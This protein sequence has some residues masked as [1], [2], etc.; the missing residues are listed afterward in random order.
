MSANDS[1]DDLRQRVQLEVARRLEQIMETPDAL[2]RY[3]RDGDGELDDEE[4]AVMRAILEAEVVHDLDD[5]PTTANP[6]QPRAAVAAEWTIDDE[7]DDP[8]IEM[9]VLELIDA[10]Y[11]VLKEIGRGAQGKTYLSR[12][13]RDARYVI[14]KELPFEQ[15]GSWKEL[16]LFEREAMALRAID[17]RAIPRFLDSF[18]L[19]VDDG[20]PRFFLVQDFVSGDPLDVVIARGTRLGENEIVAF[21]RHMLDTLHY[22]HSMSPP[23]IHRDIKPSNI[24]KT[25]AGYALVDFGAVQ[26]IAHDE[27][28]G[29][30]VVGT[31]GYM[32]PEQFGGRAEPASDLYALGAAMVHILTHTHPSKLPQKR[33]KLIWRDRAKNVT[34]PLAAFVDKLIEPM[35]EDRFESAAQ[36]RAALDNLG[37]AMVLE[38]QTRR[39][40]QDVRALDFGRPAHADAT[41]RHVG[42]GLMV[43]MSQSM[44]APRLICSG[45]GFIVGVTLSIILIDWTWM[46]IMMA[47]GLAI[48]ESWSGGPDE[49]LQMSRGGQF[50][51]VRQDKTSRRET[52]GQ[53]R[54]LAL[55]GSRLHIQTDSG[56]IVSVGQH[57]SPATRRWVFAKVDDF[58]RDK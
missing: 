27:T 57:C 16:E 40:E 37:G 10:R 4:W 11:E 13:R 9:P 44:V 41:I 45:L 3:D 51:F 8:S 52:S 46:F 21:A 47:L 56:A 12:R 15:M 55:D 58:L 30:T 34:A 35:L 42:P 25:G 6:E 31:S 50:L 24:I 5:A 36:A 43:D 29:S 39:S 26:L 20:P 7:V 23:I 17:H 53:V 54:R 18:H 1:A 22:L 28:G 2:K 14:V 48:S 33:L 38:R 19:E 49:T 32:P